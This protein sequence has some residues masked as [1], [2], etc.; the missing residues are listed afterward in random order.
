[1]SPNDVYGWLIEVYKPRLVEEMDP[2]QAFGHAVSTK[3]KNTITREN[4]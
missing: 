3:H 1:M 2:S 4:Q